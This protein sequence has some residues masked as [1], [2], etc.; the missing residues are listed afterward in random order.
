VS[1][2]ETAINRAASRENDRFMV[3]SLVT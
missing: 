2:V 1:G 3:V